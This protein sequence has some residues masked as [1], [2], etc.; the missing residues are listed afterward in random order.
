MA[1]FVVVRAPEDA[2]TL[3]GW[4]RHFA[5]ALECGV[6]A[7]MALEQDGDDVLQELTPAE[8]EEHE[9]R[10]LAAIGRAIPLEERAPTPAPDQES[11]EEEERPRPD[12]AARA[13]Y[14]EKNPI[15]GVREPSFPQSK[16]YQ[17]IAAG[18][19]L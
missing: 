16:R 13:P 14:L 18:T 6:L 17:R 11:E 2:S 1:V 19:G 7:V 8:A 10:T 4:A 9:D 3:L 15:T 5:H 12:F